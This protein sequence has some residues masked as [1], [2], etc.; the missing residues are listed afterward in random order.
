MKNLFLQT[1]SFWSVTMCLLLLTFCLIGCEKE[2][3][4]FEDPTVIN[5]KN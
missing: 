5:A 1:R 4:T 3:I 2:Q